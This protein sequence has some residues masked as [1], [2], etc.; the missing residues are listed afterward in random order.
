M[1]PTVTV[2][3]LTVPMYGLL[4]LGGCILGV[5]I[6][7]FLPVRRDIPR[8]DIF[9]CALFALVGAVVGAKLLYL[10]I[11][12][13]D[14]IAAHAGAP[15]TLDD[16]AFLIQHGYVFYGGLIGA[17]A[18]VF[19]YGKAFRLA[20]WP[21][22]DSLVPSVPL[23]H[24]IGRAGCFCAGCCYGRPMEPPWG[25]YFAAGSSA[26]YGVALFPVQL[27]ESA[28]DLVLF[29]ALFV[30]SRKSRADRRVTGLYISGYGVVRF[31][32]EF[33]RGDA[34][35]GGFWLFSTSQW[36][37]LAAV[38]LGLFFALR[39]AKKQNAA[40]TDTPAIP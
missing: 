23:G 7:V 24:A 28:L 32:L 25:V 31:A 26:P 29:A 8:Q 27:L 19:I 12:L 22:A 21:L 9:F 37:S 6:A 5:L 40:A 1:L 17:V 10:A 15:W 38:P 39:G 4:I 16:V 35:R 20:F 33:F 13:P 3:G 34:D 30:Y 18:G 14:I 36:I 11:S 2:L